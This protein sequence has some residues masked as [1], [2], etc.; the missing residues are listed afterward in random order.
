MCLA[1]A[2][3]AGAELL[4]AL[5]DAELRA[6]FVWVPMLPGDGAEGAA[7][8]AE[9]FA[10]GRARHYWD[11]ERVLSRRLAEELGMGVRFAWD[12]YMA[13][14][15]GAAAIGEPVFWMHQL[16]GVTAAPRLDVGAW[17]GM[18]EGLLARAP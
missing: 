12:M 3:G 14:P 17:R 18:V 2:S 7:A 15:R 5:L 8:A 13:Y 10:E 1:G 16:P 11:S 4:R 6:Y 9:R